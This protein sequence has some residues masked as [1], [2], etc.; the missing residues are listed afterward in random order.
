[1]IQIMK[2]TYDF[3]MKCHK[4]TIRTVENIKEAEEYC[5]TKGW[6]NR[7]YKKNIATGETIMLNKVA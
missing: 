7:G 2:Y 1:M 5:V 3:N 4:R 6:G